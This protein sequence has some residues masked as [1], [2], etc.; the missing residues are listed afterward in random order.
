MNITHS[1]TVLSPDQMKAKWLEWRA[2]GQWLGYVLMSGAPPRS[3]LIWTTPNPLPEWE[4]LAKAVEDRPTPFIW[5]ALLYRDNET[6]V[7]VRQIDG[8]WRVNVTDWA[9][10]APQTLI[11]VDSFHHLYLLSSGIPG[12]PMLH[13][14]E[15]WIAEAD[16]CCMGMDVLKPAYCA[17]V[18]WS[19]CEISK[20]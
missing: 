1:S 5:E 8:Q 11:D 17:F 4:T 2:A 13:F 20:N 3:D 10:I 14:V 16:P 6:S 18:G 7:T 12:N 9:G 19:A 15:R